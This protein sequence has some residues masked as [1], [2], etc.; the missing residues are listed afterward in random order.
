MKSLTFVLITAVALT[1]TAAC[2]VRTRE[3]ASTPPP[4]TTVVVQPAPAAPAPVTPAPAPGVVVSPAPSATVVTP[5]PAPGVVVAS[6]SASVATQVPVATWCGGAYSA[7][8]GTSFGSC[9]R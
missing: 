1:A 6:P 2:S 5:A 3:V 9:P 7:S 8:A 4:A